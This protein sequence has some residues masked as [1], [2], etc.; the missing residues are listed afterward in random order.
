LAGATR[1]AA[2]ALGKKLYGV[3]YAQPKDAMAEAELVVQVKQR[4]V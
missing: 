4:P 1:K 3:I 2:L